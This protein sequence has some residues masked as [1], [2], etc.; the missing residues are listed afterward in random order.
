MTSK[1]FCFQLLKKEG[2]FLAEERRINQEDN[3]S[4]PVVKWIYV[5][6]KYLL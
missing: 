2:K 5:R 4:M 6:E 1:D 3:L